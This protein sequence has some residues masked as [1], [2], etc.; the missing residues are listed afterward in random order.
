MAGVIFITVA[1]LAELK[2][3]IKKEKEASIA[4]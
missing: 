4:L 1:Y 2:K 3:S